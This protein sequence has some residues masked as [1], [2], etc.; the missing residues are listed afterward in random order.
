M[1]LYL[2][3]IAFNPFSA[4]ALHL[5]GRPAAVHGLLAKV[6]DG[7]G[8][9]V[10]FRID[11]GYEGPEILVQ[12][13]EICD[14]E[15]LDLAE[16]TLR[17]P[18]ET[19]EYDL[20]GLTEGGVYSFRL[21][22]RPSKTFARGSEDKAGKRVD[23]RTDEERLDWLG[24]KGKVGGFSIRSVGLTIVNQPI[25]KGESRRRQTFESVRFDGELVVADVDRLR[26]CIRQ[27]VGPQKAFGFG[28]LSL[29]V[30]R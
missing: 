26:E 18:A 10:L 9:R 28:L 6:F 11:T 17:F 5:C 24:R 25:Q 22:A 21:L 27:G 3:R 14:W 19:K 13:E 23:L 8:G 4:E 16:R 15:R 1:S 20:G 12:S 30:L 29:G 2:S 7:G